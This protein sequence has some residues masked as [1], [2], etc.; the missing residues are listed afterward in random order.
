MPYH[1][2]NAMKKADGFEKIQMAVDNLKQGME[3]E[4]W[5]NMNEGAE[6]W[7]SANADDH[8]YVEMGETGTA[9]TWLYD[10]A[11]DHGYYHEDEDSVREDD[12]K[13]EIDKLKEAHEDDIE[14]LKE[15]IKS[16]IQAGWQVENAHNAEIDR[17]KTE[18]EYTNSQVF[19]LQDQIERLQKENKKHISTIEEHWG[20]DLVVRNKEL[21]KE[22][23]DASKQ[24]SDFAE[25]IEM[26]PDDMEDKW[27]DAD[28]K[29]WRWEGDEKD[30]ESEE[31]E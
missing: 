14:K 9:Q 23:E 17:L 1:T 5:V 21:K 4:C 11:E 19:E 24:A 26:L 7:L 3:D 30:E 2:E 18:E 8:G 13:D 29:D 20:V 12:L 15:I 16:Q 6:E 28:M 31:D 27:W 10:N 25:M 22:H